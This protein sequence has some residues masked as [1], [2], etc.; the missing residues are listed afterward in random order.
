MFIECKC[1][2]LTNIFHLIYF[3]TKLATLLL[4]FSSFVDN[5]NTIQILK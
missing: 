2:F 1:T 3:M 4:S 5:F